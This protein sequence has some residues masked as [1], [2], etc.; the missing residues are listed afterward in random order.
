M[1]LLRSR[2][3]FVAQTKEK[4]GI[5]EFRTATSALFAWL[6]DGETIYR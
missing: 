5:S 6:G 2:Q 4:A 3:N 1:M